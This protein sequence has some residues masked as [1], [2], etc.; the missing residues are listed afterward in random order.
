MDQQQYMQNQQ[1][2]QIGGITSTSSGGLNNIK[3]SQMSH[4]PSESFMLNRSYINMNNTSTFIGGDT[5]IE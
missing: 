3:L 5:L 1:Q 4:R 2:Q